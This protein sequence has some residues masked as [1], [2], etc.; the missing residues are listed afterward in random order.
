MNTIDYDEFVG[1]IRD[2][3]NSKLQNNLEEFKNKNKQDDDIDKILNLCVSKGIRELIL[4]NNDDD[5]SNLARASYVF[6]DREFSDDDDSMYPM[7]TNDSKKEQIKSIF[8]SINKHIVDIDIQY[9]HLHSLNIAT[10]YIVKKIPDYEIELFNKITQ[11]LKDTMVM[12]NFNLSMRDANLVTIKE[13]FTDLDKSY[14]SLVVPDKNY[15]SLQAQILKNILNTINNLVVFYGFKLK[16]DNDPKLDQ[17][18]IYYSIILAE[19]KQISVDTI[20]EEVFNNPIK[21]N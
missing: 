1:R 15:N 20:L 14:L 17:E 6:L 9:Y 16:R 18:H 11:A 2:E 4:I 10:T 12:S 5:F 21:E 19:D 8:K 3:I 7:L 13:N